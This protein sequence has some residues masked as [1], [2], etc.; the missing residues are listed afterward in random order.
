ME[1]FYGSFLFPYFFLPLGYHQSFLSLCASSAKVKIC[2][3]VCRRDDGGDGSGSIGVEGY[4]YTLLLYELEPDGALCGLVEGNVVGD[5]HS[6][7]A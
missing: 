1:I 6:A 7:S 2:F 4:S 5:A 3:A